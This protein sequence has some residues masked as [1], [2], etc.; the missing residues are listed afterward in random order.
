MNTCQGFI[1]NILVLYQLC[2]NKY[3]NK[4]KVNLLLGFFLDEHERYYIYLTSFH[5]LRK[6]L[7]FRIKKKSLN[8]MFSILKNN[9]R[10]DVL[11]IK[12]DSRISIILIFSYFIHTL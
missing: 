8:F 4:V 1:F 10:N 3:I 7:N 12:L 5:F 11:K 6:V 9:G 2:P